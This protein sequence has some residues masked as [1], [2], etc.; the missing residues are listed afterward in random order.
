MNSSSIFFFF[1]NFTYSCIS[2]RPIVAILMELELHELE[3]HAIFFFFFKFD[4]PIL[5]F[6]QIKFQ[7]RG[8][9]LINLGKWAKRLFFCTKSA[10][11]H[12][13]PLIMLVLHIFTQTLSHVYQTMSAKVIVDPCESDK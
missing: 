12:F 13:G 5:D 6:L 11:A 7:N 4:R 10:F 1:L 3:F 9:S 2:C 8:I